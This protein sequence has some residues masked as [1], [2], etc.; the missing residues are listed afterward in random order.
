MMEP[1]NWTSS[2]IVGVVSYLLPGFL[3]AWVFFGLTSH[4]KQTPFERV[5]QA[6]IF[7]AIVQGLNAV[8][9]WS[10]P[11]QTYLAFGEWNAN[12]D[13]VSSFL[14]ATYWHSLPTTIGFMLHCGS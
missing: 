3:A 1:L 9:R 4:P 5:V 10:Y 8:V 12:C 2:E 6:L 14:C 11:Q 13:L 7:T